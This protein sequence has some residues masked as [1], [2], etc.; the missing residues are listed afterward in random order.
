MNTVADISEFLHYQQC[1][2]QQGVLCKMKFTVCPKIRS[3]LIE[4]VD[5]D[6]EY[7]LNATNTE[8]IVGSERCKRV[9]IGRTLKEV[10][11]CKLNEETVI[12]IANGCCDQDD[13][14]KR[15]Y[16]QSIINIINRTVAEPLI[17]QCYGCHR[18]SQSLKSCSRCGAPLYCSEECQKRDWP[19][20][21]YL[22]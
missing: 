1:S 16:H 6:A 21:R 4:P 5:V 11:N 22:C 20:H 17:N 15:L 12:I 18:E 2:L 19:A 8:R 9:L 3:F 14:P 10:M 7:L 13:C